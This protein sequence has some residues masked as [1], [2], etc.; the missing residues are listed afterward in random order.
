[1]ESTLRQGGTDPDLRLIETMLWDGTAIPRLHLHMA[2]LA[3]GAQALGWDKPA[4]THALQ[5]L[6]T[7]PARLRLTHARN[8]QTH[9]ET[10]PLPAA[11][12]LW[13]LM[14]APIPM[15]STDPWLTLKS[16]HR[17]TYDT[18][19]ATLPAHI[20][21]AI[22]ANEKGEVCDGT[23]TTL[24]FDAGAGL[25]TPPLS[26]GLLPGVLRADMLSRGHCVEATLMAADLPDVRLWVG[27]ALRG[28]TPATFIA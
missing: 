3:R 12:P 7:N 26:C 1:M 13:H 11:K 5:N 20:D 16:T 10:S 14:L 21:E 17:T 28:L 19:R 15:Q 6:P 23:I 27:N 9:V 25:C 22:F 24:F 18:T 4:V 8:G 2:R